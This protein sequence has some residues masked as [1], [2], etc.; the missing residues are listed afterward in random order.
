MSEVRE[1]R[2]SGTV[3]LRLALAG[4][5]RLVV[6]AAFAL[7]VGDALVTLWQRGDY[8]MRR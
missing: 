7:I 1:R 4:F 5:A 8:F 6:L 3:D 2:R